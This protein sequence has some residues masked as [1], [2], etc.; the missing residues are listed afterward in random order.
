MLESRSFDAYINTTI[1]MIVMLG[2]LEINI[3]ISGTGIETVK[4]DNCK[5]VSGNDGGTNG[6]LAIM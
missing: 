4:S 5:E 1:S 6:I 2:H 3:E